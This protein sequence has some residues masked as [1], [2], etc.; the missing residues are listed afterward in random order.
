MNTDDKIKELYTG[1]FDEIHASDELLRKVS[2]MTETTKKR[3]IRTAVKVAYAAAAAAV[4]L[5]AGNVIAYAS[6]GEML[7]KILVNGEEQTVSATQEEDGSY[8]FTCSD[9]DGYSYNVLVAGD[10][11]NDSPVAVGEFN[12]F[13]PEIVKENGKTY[14]AVSEDFKADITADVKED[15]S[16]EGSFEYDGMN[17]YYIVD[18]DG[19]LWLSGTNGEAADE[20]GIE[21]KSFTS[22]DPDEAEIE[23]FDKK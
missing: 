17:Y 23:I 1:V 7:L 11:D 5:V 6:T 19:E 10:L 9:E 15:G 4:V 22:T 2:N 13:T 21:T 14:I 8:S 3:S 12:T 18:S 20:A 16:A